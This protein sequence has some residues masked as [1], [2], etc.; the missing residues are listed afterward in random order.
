MLSPKGNHLEPVRGLTVELFALEGKEIQRD[1]HVWIMGREPDQWHI[2][3]KDKSYSVARHLVVE[4]PV[5]RP[6]IEQLRTLDGCFGLSESAFD[7]VL[8]DR[9][10]YYIFMRCKQH[11]KLFLDDTRGTSVWYSRLIYVGDLGNSSYDHVW[12]KFH[13]IS[14][15]MLNY[16]CVAF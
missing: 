2:E 8:I 1:T 14:D 6:L 13:D 15:D 9:D 16:M 7:E 11:G 5:P 4:C 10:N 12:S 3:Y